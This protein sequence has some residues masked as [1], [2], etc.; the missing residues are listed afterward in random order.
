MQ[1]DIRVMCKRNDAFYS[2]DTQSRL[3][4]AADNEILGSQ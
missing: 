2:T 3:H 1:L 4:D